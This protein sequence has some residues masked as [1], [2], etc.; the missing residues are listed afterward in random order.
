M[1]SPS[2]HVLRGALTVHL[3]VLLLSLHPSH[4]TANPSQSQQHPSSASIGTLADT[5]NVEVPPALHAADRDVNARL[6]QLRGA[7]TALHSTVEQ[8]RQGH[9]NHTL[10]SEVKT[11]SKLRRLAATIA[12][13]AEANGKLSAE[14]RSL[15]A[16]RDDLSTRLSSLEERASSAA[17]APVTPQASPFG[18]T[19]LVAELV[20]EAEALLRDGGLEHF[21]SPRF[22]PAVAGI[23]SN[24]VLLAPLAAAAM[25]L[26]AAKSEGPRRAFG[27]LLTFDAAFVSALVIAAGLVLGDPIAALRHISETNL[28]L[29]QVVLAAVVGAAI[30]VGAAVLRAGPDRR[31][32][33]GI[34]AVKTA[35]AVPYIV[36]VWAPVMDGDDVPVAMPAWWYLVSSL[37][38]WTCVRILRVSDGAAA[39]THAD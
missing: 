18:L 36:N 19:T 10:L 13:L 27:A 35:L 29:L 3:F 31:R 11:R 5:T 22:S 14:N 9:T 21:A 24:G 4:S 23:V 12:K 16:A 7:L 39:A 38:G 33:A 26:A 30:I 28:A 20:A 15:R 17:A 1:S 2:R 34:L 6:N 32:V 37:V 25:Y 8:L